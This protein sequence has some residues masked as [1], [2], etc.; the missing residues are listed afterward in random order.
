MVVALKT[1]PGPPDPESGIRARS[2]GPSE[3]KYRPD[4][5]GLRAV[6][7]L[8]VVLYHVG[9][10]GVSGGFVGVD[11]FFVISGFLITS[12]LL[13]AR[14]VGLRPMLVDFYARRARRILP[15]LVV[16]TCTT[17]IIGRVFLLANGEQQ[18]LA[19]S[20]IAAALFVSNIFFFQLGKDYFAGPAE[21]QPL[22]HTWSHGLC[23]YT[24]SRCHGEL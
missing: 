2:R 24:L 4:I 19:K 7:V 11:V 22:L 1:H 13:A 9:A 23:R 18:D 14:D 21:Q 3:T 5:D 15:S 10:T 16:V 17:L 8:A 12:N 20:A 6:A